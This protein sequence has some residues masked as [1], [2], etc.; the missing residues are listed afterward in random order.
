[1]LEN[2]LSQWW[3]HKWR[4]KWRHVLGENSWFL[5]RVYILIKAF[6]SVF[7]ETHMKEIVWA[8]WKSSEICESTSVKRRNGTCKIANFKT[9]LDELPRPTV[10]KRYKLRTSLTTHIFFETY[11][12]GWL[13]QKI[14]PTFVRR[15]RARA[16]SPILRLFRTNPLDNCKSTIRVGDFSNHTNVL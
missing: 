11:I 6:F 1:M 13:N 3:R 15:S 16:G 4:H 10:T 12:I 8:F 9:F 14:R 2:F 5:N 7:L